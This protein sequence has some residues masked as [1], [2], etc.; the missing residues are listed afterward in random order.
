MYVR[1]SG[2]PA[3]RPVL[4]LHG[5]MLDGN[6]WN[7]AA[8]AL[9][10]RRRV[11]VPD[12]PGYGRSPP[13]VPW[14]FAGVRRAIER[15]LAAR[16]I[17]E[18]D[19][20]GYSAGTHH[21]LSLAL[22]GAVRVPR[23]YLL[24][25]IAGADPEVLEAFDGHAR[26]ARGGADVAAAF[27]ALAAPAAWAAGHAAEVEEVRQAARRTPLATIA[28][29]LEATTRLPDL[30]QRLGDVRADVVVRCGTEDR[31]TPLAWSEAIARGLPRARLEIADGVGHL[32]LVQDRAA[33]LASMVAHL[34]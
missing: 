21:A 10:V 9:A 25:A 27:V 15:E 7:L 29:E 24:G 34:A 1:D 5:Q 13:L 26:A 30:R 11:L 16:G 17:D 18:V 31:N 6:F 32:Y 28:A 3:G 20:G 23:L 19:V 2:D 12:L 22:S 33:T 8:A 4:L 14:S